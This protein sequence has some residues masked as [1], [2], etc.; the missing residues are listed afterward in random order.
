MN[1]IGL[2]LAFALEPWFAQQGTGVLWLLCAASIAALVFGADR[3]V[4][5]AV[6]LAKRLGMSPVIIGAT[7]VSLGTTSPEMFTSV[8]AAF[9]GRS[10]LALAN[11]V[12][13]IICDT[14]LIFGLSC[15]LASLPLD[16][17][18]L[19]RHGWLQL[20]AGV[21]LAGTCVVLAAVAGGIGTLG[22]DHAATWVVLPRWVGAGMAVLLGVYLWLSVRWARR[23]PE[24]AANLAARAEHAPPRR[25]G[26]AGAAVMLAVGIGVVI[27]G[28][29]VL[30]PAVTV[31]AERYR[32]PTDFLGATVVAFGTSLPELVTAIAAI[33]KGHKGLLVGNIVGADILNVLFVVGLSS[34]AAELKVP[35][36]FY[37]LHFPVMLS[38]LVLLR[39]FIQTGG[40]TFR[41]WQGLPLLAIYVG[42]V[43]ALLTFAPHLAGH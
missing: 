2:Q 33:A 37:Y 14:G 17:F 4:E 7:V 34:C 20:G 29:N 36:T 5:A 18:I 8:T 15:L 27:A 32:L 6:R 25:A 23:R 38:V 41:R 35:P 31:L 11:G 21:L 22:P 30:I 1:L 24:I 19:N 42:Y 12:G 13:S 9:R 40:T 28:S 43:A 26:A 10:G 16:R 39:V 3:T